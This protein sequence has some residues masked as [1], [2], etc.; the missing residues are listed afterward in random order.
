[1]DRDSIALVTIDFCAIDDTGVSMGADETTT[2]ETA[3]KHR[4]HVA[5]RPLAPLD[6]RCRIQ[7]LQ[8]AWRHGVSREVSL[9]SKGLYTESHIL[10]SHSQP[11]S[12]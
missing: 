12:R 9:E 4:T 10:L 2:F 8:K 3:V 11:V 5:R 1:V 6:I 7:S